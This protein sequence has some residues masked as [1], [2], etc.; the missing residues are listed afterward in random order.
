VKIITQ[1]IDD[2]KYSLEGI[3]V[4]CGEDL[5]IIICG[6]TKHHIGAAALGTAYTK[7]DSPQT[8][9]ASVSTICI[10]GH[11]DDE[12]ARQAASF[13][14]KTY[15]CTASVNVGIHIDDAEAADIQRLKDNFE[16]LIQRISRVMGEEKTDRE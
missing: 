11:R 2:G 1:K 5:Y 10:T 6:G 8:V 13:F 14:A 16:A 9:S 12:L 3:A 4:F 15:H 7:K